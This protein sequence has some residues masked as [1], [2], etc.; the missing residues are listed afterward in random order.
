MYTHA[1]RV[2]VLPIDVFIV[3]TGQ[4][5]CMYKIFGHVEFMPGPCTCVRLFLCV[6]N[7]LG[8]DESCCKALGVLAVVWLE[9]ACRRSMFVAV[10]FTSGRGVLGSVLGCDCASYLSF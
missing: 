8:Q 4:L 2:A 7:G 6:R 10:L 5:F 9:Y 3:V 1:L